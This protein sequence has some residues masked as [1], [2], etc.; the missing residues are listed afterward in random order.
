[1]AIDDTLETLETLR[2]DVMLA[3]GALAV[4]D[5]ELLQEIAER[6]FDRRDL[7]AI[8][9]APHDARVVDAVKCWRA[10]VKR[11]ARGEM[12]PGPARG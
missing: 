7:L 6:L 10:L 4:S 1:M 3:I 11:A 9:L 2:N 8:L 5:N 12:A